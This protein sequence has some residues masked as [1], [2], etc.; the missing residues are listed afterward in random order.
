LRFLAVGGV[1]LDLG[2]YGEAV[3]IRERALGCLD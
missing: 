1:A 3:A 2:Q